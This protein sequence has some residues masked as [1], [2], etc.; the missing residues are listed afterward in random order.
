MKSS[1]PVP[2]IHFPG[3]STASGK[4]LGESW[5]RIRSTL[6]HSVTRIVTGVRHPAET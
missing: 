1:F 4:V 5:V 6:C 2:L 3:D